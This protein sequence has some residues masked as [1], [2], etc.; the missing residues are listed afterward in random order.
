LSMQRRLTLRSGAFRTGI[1]SLT[2]QT[3][4]YAFGLSGIEVGSG[5]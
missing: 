1:C 5:L 4:I 3:A 2:E